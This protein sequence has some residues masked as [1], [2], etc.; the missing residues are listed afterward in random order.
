MKICIII[1]VYN[2]AK[3]IKGIVRDIK[4]KGFDVIVIDDGSIDDSGNLA[5][6]AGAVVLR[7]DKKHGKGY[8]LQQG[9]SYVLKSDYEGVF[10]VD[11][12]GQHAV[13]DMDNFMK[14]IKEDSKAVV[15]GNRMADAGKMP[16]VRL[17]TNKFMS[18]IISLSIGQKITDTQC[19]FRYIPLC[20]LRDIKITSTAYEIET[21]VLM[22][23]AKAGYKIYSVGIETIYGDEISKINPLN[24][25]VKFFRYFFQELSNRKK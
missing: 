2:E 10:T 23:A 9:F 13:A 14:V 18:W 3:T 7:N 16:W 12:D 17:L 24:D 1:P 11:G 21:E 25:T 4:H 22:K 8:S 15:V 20:V 6:S 19:G 5:K